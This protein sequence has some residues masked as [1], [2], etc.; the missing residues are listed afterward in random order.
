M[1]RDGPRV[2]RGNPNRETRGGGSGNSP[3]IREGFLQKRARVLVCSR[4][5]ALVDWLTAFK[6]AADGLLTRK[7]HGVT[8]VRINRQSCIGNP[9]PMGDDGHCE[10]MRLPAC[11]CFAEFAADPLGANFLPKSPQDIT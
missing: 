2:D 11:N 10:A 5:G 6:Q 1:P 4:C 7:V 9:F 3:A 8:E